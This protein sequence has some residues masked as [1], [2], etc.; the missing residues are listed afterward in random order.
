M[1]LVNA[2]LTSIWKFFS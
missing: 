1:T 2:Q